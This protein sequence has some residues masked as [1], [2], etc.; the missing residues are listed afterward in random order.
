[1]LHLIKLAVGVRDIEHLQTLQAERLGRE[2]TLRHRTRN[3][4][5]R[6]R[7]VLD[8]GSL[9]WVISGAVLARQPIDDIVQDQRL[10]GTPCAAFVLRPGLTPLSGR[11]MKPF[12]GWRY[13]PAEDAP[14]DR[15]A[16]GAIDGIDLMPAAMRRELSTLCLL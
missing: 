12:Q 8:G 11:T 5:R 16:I 7:E 13:L 6:F 3:F 10:D 9:Y 4:P 15:D 2:G 14:P 1:M